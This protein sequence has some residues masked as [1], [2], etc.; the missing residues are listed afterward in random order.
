MNKTSKKTLICFVIAI[1]FFLIF[2]AF[3]AVVTL[4]DV[5]AIGPDGSSVGLAT[6]NKA[7]QALSR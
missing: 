2:A 5:Q 1:S 6:H 7:I 3:T 4:V